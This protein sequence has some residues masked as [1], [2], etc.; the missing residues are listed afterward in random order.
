MISILIHFV[1][2]LWYLHFH[3]I[4]IKFQFKF[5]KLQLL[6]IMVLKNEKLIQLVKYRNE[7]R[8]MMN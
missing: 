2:V 7:V 1:I 8:K 6:S 3:I 4:T 5:C